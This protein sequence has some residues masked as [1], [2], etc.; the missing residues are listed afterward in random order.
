MLARTALRAGHLPRRASSWSLVRRADADE[1]MFSFCTRT[2]RSWSYA[3]SRRPRNDRWQRP[4]RRGFVLPVVDRLPALR[5]LRVTGLRVA[6]GTKPAQALRDRRFVSLRSLNRESFSRYGWSE[7]PGGGV[8]KHA[9]TRGKAKPPRCRSYAR[10]SG[11]IVTI[12]R[13]APT[14]IDPVTFRFSVERSTN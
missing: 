8:Q 12:T 10:V 2:A 6:S 4:H 9:L 13:V 11:V 14:G 5:V 3:R 1:T 7:H